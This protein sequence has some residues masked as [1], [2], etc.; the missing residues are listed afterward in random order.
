MGQG[1]SDSNVSFSSPA[2]E[3]AAAFESLSGSFPPVATVMPLYSSQSFPS[4]PSAQPTAPWADQQTAVTAEPSISS[5]QAS[6]PPGSS[7]AYFPVAVHWFYCTNIELRQIWH[8]FSVV[9]SA[10]L[11]SAHQAFISGKVMSSYKNLRILLQYIASDK[12]K[13]CCTQTLEIV[14]LWQTHISRVACYNTELF[15]VG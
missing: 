13:N 15:A 6:A 10:N 2:L 8:P 11:E 14:T 7:A 12:L 1:S 9:D 3:A 4:P 5:R